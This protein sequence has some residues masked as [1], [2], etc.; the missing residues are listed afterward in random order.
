VLFFACQAQAGFIGFEESE[1][2]INGA[3]YHQPDEF[4]WQGEQDFN[5]FNVVDHIYTGYDSDHLLRVLAAAADGSPERPYR[6]DWK[7]LVPMSGQVQVSYT[8]LMASGDA[9]HCSV[10]ALGETSDSGWGPYIGM[11][12]DGGERTLKHFDGSVWHTIATGIETGLPATFYDVFLDIDLD[13]N[14]LDAVVRKYAD[15]SLFASVSLTLCSNLADVPNELA[16][17]MVSNEGTNYGGAQHFHFY[18][19]LTYIPE[20]ASL[21]L[22]GLTGLAI[23]RRRRRA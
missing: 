19:N 6:Y 16:Y 13:N 14:T 21:T 8:F 23:L 3:L 9:E 18:D 11:N 10:I 1:G 22:F 4:G 5:Y 15:G 2:Y 17:I 20:P 12:A 7:R